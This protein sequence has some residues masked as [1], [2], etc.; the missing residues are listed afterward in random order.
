M[1][2]RWNDTKLPRIDQKCHSNALRSQGWY[3]WEKKRG[4]IVNQSAK[5]S[6]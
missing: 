5:E 1:V 4:K 2:A 3:N 6:I